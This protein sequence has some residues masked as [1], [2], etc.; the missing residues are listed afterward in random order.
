MKLFVIA[1]GNDV[2]TTHLDTIISL[3]RGTFN[4]GLVI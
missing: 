4:I 2:G 3:K 1:M